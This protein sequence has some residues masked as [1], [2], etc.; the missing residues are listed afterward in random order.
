M[1]Q[2]F[3]QIFKLLWLLFFVLLIF[4][5]RDIFEVK[6]GLIIFVLTLTVITIL[7]SLE[8]KREWNEI[9]DNLDDDEKEL[10]S[11]KH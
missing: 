6:I 3:T 10:F 5:D 1:N 8:S 7:R 9:V 2:L 4:L 11:H